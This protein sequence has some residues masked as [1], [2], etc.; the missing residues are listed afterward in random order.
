[1]STARVAA[2][3]DL[4]RTLLRCNSGSKWLRFLRERGE[5]DAW[6]MA[7]SVLWLAK[8]KLAILDMERLA[9]HLIADLRGDSER[10]MRDKAAI[11]WERDVR[12]AISELALAALAE[13]RASRTSSRCCPAP[14]SSSPIRSPPTSASSTSCAPASTSKAASSSAPASARPA[15]A[16]ARSSTPS[17]SPPRTTSTSPRATSTPIATAI[18]R[19]F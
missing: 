6:M 3:F 12:P 18:C 4:D 13:H 16:T 9:T 11:F 10:E 1:M 7:R 15:T 19:C 2:F 8:Y 5:V 17:A 14:P